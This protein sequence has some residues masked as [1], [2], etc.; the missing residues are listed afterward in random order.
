M[1]ICHVLDTVLHVGTR[2]KIQSSL[3][4]CSLVEEIDAFLMYKKFC[5]R[6]KCGSME[7]RHRLGRTG[8]RSQSRLSSEVMLKS[9]GAH[10]TRFSF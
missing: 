5:D 9:L 7:D 4:T 1:N 6:G 10:E 3:R 2:D 8:E